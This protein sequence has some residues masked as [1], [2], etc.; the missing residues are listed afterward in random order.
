[1]TIIPGCAVSPKN[2]NAGEKERL[3]QQAPFIFAKRP[4]GGTRPALAGEGDSSAGEGGWSIVLLTFPEQGGERAASEALTRLQS[5]PNFSDGYIARRSGAWVLAYGSYTGPGDP[6]AQSDLARLKEIASGAMLVPGERAV[7][8]GSNPEWD[9]STL[10][11]RAGKG[12]VRTLQV[13]IYRH[14]DK[15]RTPTAQELSQFR[16]AAE[17]AVGELRAAGEDAYYY[18]GPYGSTVTVGVFGEQDVVTSVRDP[19][20]G[21]VTQLPRARESMAIMDARSRHPLNL[22]NGAPILEKMPGTGEQ[23]EQASFLVRIPD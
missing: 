5:Q 8:E 20:N 21:Q 10:R 19:V 7:A 3:A 22:L 11:S 17:K 13:A 9:L 14:A 16:A 2:E 23:R 12:A 6:A 18:H 1:L 15:L 4:Q